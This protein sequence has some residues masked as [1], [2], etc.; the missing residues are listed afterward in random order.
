MKWNSQTRNIL[1]ICNN[2]L[3]DNIISTGVIEYLQNHTT[4]PCFTIICSSISADLYHH[5]PNL[6]EII[7]I[8]KK[9][10]HMHWLDLWHKTR[11]KKFDLI[12]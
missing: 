5:M 8:N 6:D 12:V 3:G 11:H 2:R 1:V 9:R 4:N 7:M 10:Y